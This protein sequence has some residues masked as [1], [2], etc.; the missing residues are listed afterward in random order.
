M[1]LSR[2][3]APQAH[4]YH[5]RI[6]TRHP[7]HALYRFI[8]SMP[9]R[10]AAA[11]RPVASVVTPFRRPIVLATSASAPFPPA[12]AALTDPDGLLAVGGDLSPQ[13]LLNAY[14]HGIF[15]VVLGWP[16]DPVV[17]PRPAHGLSH[18]RR[19]P[20][21]PLQAPAPRKHLDGS[22]RHRLRTGDRCLRCESAPRPGRH[23]DHRGDA[24]GLYRLAPSRPR[25]FDRGIRRRAPGRRDLRRR[26]RP[27]VF[28]A[29]ACS[30]GK[31]AVPRWHWPPWPPICMAED[32]H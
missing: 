30:V 15:P 28:L 1:G 24:A 13:R 5:R 31:A 10:H 22:R 25:A 2:L 8:I 7:A 32:G 19:A 11:I 20:V 21:F 17:E 6:R 12:E 18:R 27:D 4:L 14:A 26:G 29:K 3:G 16:T 9:A 23:L